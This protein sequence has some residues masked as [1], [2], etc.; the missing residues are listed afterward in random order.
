MNY[1]TSELRRIS[2]WM[3]LL[4]DSKHISQLSQAHKMGIFEKIV[5]GFKTHMM[6]IKG[7]FVRTLGSMIQVIQLISTLKKLFVLYFSVTWIMTHWIQGNNRF[8]QFLN[9]LD[10][11]FSINFLS[12]SVLPILPKIYCQW[13]CAETQATKI[14]NLY[15]VIKRTT[16]L[17][18][19]CSNQLLNALIS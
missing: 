6:D 8:L 18:E 7:L 2:H 12:W 10:H 19:C 15:I 9:H 17:C 4:Q 16:G 3:P 11:P 13:D 5:N 1:Q 14:Q